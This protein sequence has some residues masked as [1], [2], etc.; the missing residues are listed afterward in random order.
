LLRAGFVIATPAFSVIAFLAL[1]VLQSSWLSPDWSQRFGFWGLHVTSQITYC[2][3]AAGLICSFIGKGRVRYV[4]LLSCVVAAGWLFVLSIS[5]AIGGSAQTR[6]PVRYLIPNGY[7]GWVE[8]KHNR[9][10]APP[11]M[12]I[13]GTIQ[14][15]FDSQGF[16]VT[17]STLED[18]WAKDEYL[19]YSP[20]GSITVLPETIWGGGGKIWGSQVSTNIDHSV[21]NEFFYVGTE[22]QYSHGVNPGGIHP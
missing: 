14:R 17:S 7:V 16:S 18:G 8:V 3:A 15:K 9:A 20:D 6:H 5:A 4:S 22:D 12:T 11:D 2:S 13:G 1:L 10:G 21:F 19:Y